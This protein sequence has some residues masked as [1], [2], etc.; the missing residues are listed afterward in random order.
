MSTPTTADQAM[1]SAFQ[2]Q[3][4][5]QK[6]AANAQMLAVLIPQFMACQGTPAAAPFAAS[7]VAYGGPNLLT[8]TPIAVGA[9]QNAPEP[10]APS[11]V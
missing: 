11:I 3:A 4:D 8:P 10:A 7:I 6:Q 5:A 9:M 2:A 1:A